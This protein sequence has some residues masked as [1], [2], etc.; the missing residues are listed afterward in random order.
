MIDIIFIKGYRY[1]SI[2]RNSRLHIFLKDISDFVMLKKL[3]DENGKDIYFSTK[4]LFT[5]GKFS[6]KPYEYPYDKFGV[7]REV[8]L[9][10]FV[11]YDSWL[12]SS[13]FYLSDKARDILKEL[14]IVEE[15]QIRY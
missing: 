8:D 2:K 12:D 9:F 7:L 15:V 13:I 1:L 10:I 6:L 5:I 11:K 3:S 14:K 4:D